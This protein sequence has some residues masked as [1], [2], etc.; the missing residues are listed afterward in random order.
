VQVDKNSS[1]HTYFHTCAR[2]NSSREK[3]SHYLLLGEA[4]TSVPLLSPLF[5]SA[6]IARTALSP[7]KQLW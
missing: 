7:L 4:D 1:T 5:L 6:C 2:S 3:P